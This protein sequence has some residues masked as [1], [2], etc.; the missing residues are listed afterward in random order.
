[1]AR[2]NEAYQTRFSNYHCA[3]GGD[4]A[5]FGVDSLLKQYDSDINPNGKIYQE[6]KNLIDDKELAERLHQY[7]IKR[8]TDKKE[9]NTKKP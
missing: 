2:R 1:M 8:W 6:V 5:Y 4:H 7:G 9:V 3:A